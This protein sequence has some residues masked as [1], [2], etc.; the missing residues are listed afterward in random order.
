MRE[1]SI[2]LIDYKSIK[3]IEILD[4][5][6]DHKPTFRIREA[7]VLHGTLLSISEYTRWGRALFFTMQNILHTE[8]QKL[9]HVLARYYWKRK[10]SWKIEWAL[11]PALQH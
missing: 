8:L 4:D 1:L 7:L 9:Y 2:G 6:I 10:H 3:A 5:W 11:S